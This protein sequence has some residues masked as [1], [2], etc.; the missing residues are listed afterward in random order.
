MENRDISAPRAS[1]QRDHAGIQLV[2][3]GD[4]LRD[5]SRPEISGEDPGKVA[6]SYVTGDLG[7]FDSTLPAFLLAMFRDRGA[8]D[9]SLDGMPENLRGLME[10]ALSVPE[11]IEAKSQ[12]DQRSPLAKLG[13]VSLSVWERLTSVA[14]FVGLT[15]FS[16]GR[17]LTGRARFR[18]KD[19]WLI[20]QQSGVEALPIVILITFLIGA[21]LAFVG[22]VQLANFGANIYV[23]DLVGIAT[24]R[25]MGVVMTGIMMSGRTGAAFAASIG[26]MKAN[27]EIDALR[28]FG[29]NPF[30]F[31]VLP[32]VIALVL[33][34]PIL[35]IFA[36]V[37][38]IAGG[39]LVGA[40]VGIP[41]AL[42]WQETLV[43]VTLTI[44]SLGVLKSFFFGAAI[45]ICGCLQGMNAGNSSA[46]VGE[47][48]TRAVV[49]S[50]TSVIVIDSAFAAIFTLLGI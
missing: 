10:L 11:R 22:N 14:E 26:S 37:M 19:F 44:A 24:L 28:T 40:L 5:G 15:L 2:L 27:E 8:A 46:A 23:A 30:D 41:P 39:M 32:R 42:Y 12:A 21:I 50:I 17:F 35:T 7:E 45:A 20:V 43:S 36:N 4:W 6:E 9:P 31:L 34:M 48:T 49:A 29:F 16:L 25:E 3:S 47:A 13:G 18:G 1:W 38:G 33:M